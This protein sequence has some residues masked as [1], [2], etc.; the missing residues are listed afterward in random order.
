M[1]GCWF[2]RRGRNTNPRS[3]NS[4]NADDQ[5]RTGDAPRRTRG[6]GALRGVAGA[7]VCAGVVL[8]AVSIAVGQ[9]I[10]AAFVPGR[11]GRLLD[12]PAVDVPRP[13]PKPSMISLQ[14]VTKVYKNGIVA[15]D[16]VSVEVEKGEFVFIVGPSGSGKS[17]FIRLLLKEE[18]ADEGRH[19]RRRQEPR[20]A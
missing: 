8:V 9:A 1:S 6:A 10:G 17:T 15:L 11:G 5:R 13:S 12:S 3:A 19:L 7:R 18:D 14:H 4:T 16:D 20:E 2:V